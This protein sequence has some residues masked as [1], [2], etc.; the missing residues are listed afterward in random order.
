MK[1]LLALTL[2]A[3][4]VFALAAACTSS[5]PSPGDDTNGNTTN[6]NNDTNGG[7]A[8]FDTTRRIAVYTREDGSGTR[9]AFASITGVGDDMYLEAVVLTTGG[10]LRSSVA[11]NG[12]G[13][14]YVS[15]G[16]LNDTVKALTIGGVMPS[17]ATIVDGSY[18][19]QR[20]F[21]IVTNN[22]N[23]AN[24]LVKD[25]I[26][27]VLSAQGQEHSS[28]NWTSEGNT[29]DYTPAGLSGTL[30]IGGSTSVNPLMELLK[31]A[32][33]NLNPGVSIEI[34]GGGSGNGISEA[35]SGMIEIGMSSRELRD[36]EK[37]SLNEYTI[38]LDGVAVIVNTANPLTDID[39]ETVK[40]IFTGEITMWNEIIG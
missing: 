20:P 15:V 24:P 27:F 38:A 16:S 34:S 29:G 36:N 40:G 12:Y 23:D 11:G 33:E 19:I 7:S 5:D 18:P 1:K 4:M 6:G 32:Y 26:A 8:D 28:T 31:A 2:A 9:D 13:I 10:E 17:D 30:R 37:A 3:L 25:F 35:T 22:D 21:L 39:M 14:G